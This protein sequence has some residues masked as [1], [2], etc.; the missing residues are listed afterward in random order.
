MLV[1][2]G[3][4]YQRDSIPNAPTRERLA[5]NIALSKFIDYTWQ[6]RGVVD[7]LLVPNAELRA[8]TLSAA[9][10]VSTALGLRFGVARTFTEEKD[11]SLQ[12]GAYFRLPYADLAVTGDY[13]TRHDD[14]RIGIRLAFGLAFDPV[15]NRYR[16]TRPGPAGGGSAV[17][18]AFVDQNSNG[19]FDPGEP[20]VAN[21]SVEGGERRIV[22]DANGRAFV[23]G[24]GNAPTGRL[25]VGTDNIDDF[26]LS[27]PP[28]NVEFSPRPGH[29]IQIPYPLSPVGDVVASVRLREDGGT[30]TG[31]SS[32][33]VRL[34][35]E[36]AE[37]IEGTT[38][39]DGSV[40][41]SDVRPGTYRFELDP[42]QAARLKMRLKDPVSTVVTA[43]GAEE[44]HAEILFEGVQ[45]D[46]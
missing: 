22:T 23:T 9:R 19:H 32:V 45:N 18:H 4:D 25:R 1:S 20:P 29:V 44:I 33:R 35:R 6:V 43:D 31:I 46:S 30:M 14:W 39:F 36:G 8:I 16:V 21:V 28:P 27:G 12:A 26:Y 37:P 11:L 10:D 34:V 3:L 15:A 7:Y 41:F 38:E 40:I 2:A 42:E 5:G 13:A 24:L 17:L